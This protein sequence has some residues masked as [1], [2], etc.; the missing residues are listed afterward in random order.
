MSDHQVAGSITPVIGNPS[1]SLNTPALQISTSIVPTSALICAHR[2]FVSTS[3]AASE[4]IATTLVLGDAFVSSAATW[5]RRSLLRPVIT[6]L[7]APAWAQDRAI[8]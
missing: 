6:I 4:T 3:D 7:V 1:L 5:T 8:I 2:L